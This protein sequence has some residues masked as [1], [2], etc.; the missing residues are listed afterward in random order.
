MKKAAVWFHLLPAGLV[1]LVCPPR[2]PLCGTFHAAGEGWGP[3]DFCASC[4]AGI[5][6]LPEAR[7]RLC[8][9]PFPAGTDSAHACG[10]CLKSPPAFDRAVA[11]GLYEEA[12][13]AAIHHLKYRRRTELVRP[14]AGFMAGRLKPPFYPP[15]ADLILPVPLPARRLRARGFNQSQLLAATLFRPWQEKIKPEVLRRPVYTPPQMTLD[16]A[17]RRGNVSGAFAVARPA[18]VEKKTVIL[19]D[20]VFTTGATAGECARVLKKAGADQVLVLT[21]ARVK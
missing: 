6:P 1:D 18:Q 14:L 13:R 16:R 2:C 4:Q 5:K 11:A 20:D 8:A 19:V 9:Q 15:A 17:D 21:L 12:L 3:H 10:A 7:C